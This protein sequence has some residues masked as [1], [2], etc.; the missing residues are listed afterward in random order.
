[1]VSTSDEFGPQLWVNF[2]Q[3]RPSLMF[4]RSG[5]DNS[6]VTSSSQR[7]C[8]ANRRTTGFDVPQGSGSRLFRS[9]APDAVAGR[10]YLW[11]VFRLLNHVW[12]T[13][14]RSTGWSKSAAKGPSAWNA[15]YAR[16]DG[17]T[18]PGSPSMSDGE[19][20]GDDD[21]VDYDDVRIPLHV[22]MLKL[23]Y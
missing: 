7:D 6:T 21:D 2:N 14:V 19:A 5:A 9:L 11:Y 15:K 16:S 1:M 8:P 22:A 20:L 17:E 13:D 10:T 18:E 3:V 12:C 4:D 23:V